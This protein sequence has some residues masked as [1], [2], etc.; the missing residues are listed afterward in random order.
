MNKIN[1]YIFEDD[2]EDIRIKTIQTIKEILIIYNL[3]NNIILYNLLASAKQMI[4]QF[5][6]FGYY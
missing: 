1:N 6:K 3:M 2:D 4:Y 5:N